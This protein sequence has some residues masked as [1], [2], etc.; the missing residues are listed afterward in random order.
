MKKS[1][2]KLKDEARRHESKEAWDE[3]IRA[4]RQILQIVEEGGDETDLSLYNRIG[5]LYL[6]AGKPGEAVRYYEMAADR[7][8]EVG[9]YNG[10]IALCNKAIRHDPDRPEPYLKLARLTLAQGFISEARRWSIDYAVRALQSRDRE[11]AITLLD[12]L[13]REVAAPELHEAFAELLEER[14]EPAAAAAQ[15][16]GAYRL[17]IEREGEAAVESLRGR[18]LEL[19]PGAEIPEP[20][21]PTPA[22]A[23]ETGAAGEESGAEDEGRA[24]GV[25]VGLD[26]EELVPTV[27]EEMPA[28]PELPNLEIET[29]ADSA[30]IQD[31][32]L[33]TDSVVTS[34]LV[35]EPTI[36][37]QKPGE[38]DGDEAEDEVDPL[39]ILGL[40]SH[41]ADEAGPGQEEQDEELQDAEVEPVDIFVPPV[42]VAEEPPAA[43]PEQVI[44]IDILTGGASEL[45][46]P[47]AASEPDEESA[48]GGSGFIDL[49]DLL[50]DAVKTQGET[51]YTVDAPVPTGDEE[52][53]FMELLQQFRSQVEDHLGDEDSAS[54]YDL[55]LAFKEMGLYD[56]AIAQFQL[57][58]RGAEDPLKI[59]EELGDSFI[60]KGSYTIALKVLQGALRLSERGGGDLIG[61]FYL[62]GR[63]YEELEMVDDA[64][65]S[66]ERVLALDLEFRDAVDRL[67]RL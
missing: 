47:A 55:G 12:E 61:I 66:Y 7:Y 51:R 57:A 16:I 15:L 45:E 13:A 31:L 37:G 48:S 64:R 5:D 27:V 14:G 28:A 41:L 42:E 49:A 65:D 62:L 19:D 25:V 33:L 36:I 34:G 46:E 11:T 4:Y 17:R 8:A 30:G 29:A 52:H 40:E 44:E 50:H 54:R 2:A 20:G 18:I 24:G 38:D 3:A 67:A 9:L 23:A 6:R 1:I 35:V 22:A 63:C 26:G 43:A 60:Q 32:P 10:A 58:L 39:P 21:A 53:D 59:Y 56:E